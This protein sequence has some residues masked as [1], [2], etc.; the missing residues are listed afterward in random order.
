MAIVVSFQV[1]EHVAN[2]HEFIVSCLKLLRPGG[3]LVVGVP[4]HDGIFGRAVN[5]I[6]DMPPHHLT[7][8]SKCTFQKLADIFGLVLEEVQY[9]P[10]AAYHLKWA[11]KII[12]ENRVRDL[13][14]LS[15]RVLDVRIRSRVVAK[16]SSIMASL[17]PPR[18]DSYTGHTMV[19]VFRK[20]G[21]ELT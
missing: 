21:G 8:W 16:I 6:L 10:I 19:V 20:K 2:P 7:H 18:V 15:Y 9:E 4:S 11:R 14:G 3:K 12:W 13:T 1:L 17:F 5:S